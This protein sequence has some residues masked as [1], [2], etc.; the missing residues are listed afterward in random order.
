[1]PKKPPTVSGAMASITVFSAFS[2]M[3]AWSV[4]RFPW[5]AS[6]MPVPT[7]P[8]LTMDPFSF[9]ILPLPGISYSLPFLM[10]QKKLSLFPLIPSTAGNSPCP[11]PAGPWSTN[12]PLPLPGILPYK[13]LQRHFC[14]KGGIFWLF[15]TKIKPLLST[16]AGLFRPASATGL[17]KRPS[18]APSERI[19][20]PS[21]RKSSSIV[22]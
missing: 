7:G 17:P 13:I 15:K 1:M 22:S 18:P 3:A 10:E 9:P 4:W 8:L 16:N 19:S 2:S 11:P 12:L 14:R 6:S 5:S 21:G 20:R